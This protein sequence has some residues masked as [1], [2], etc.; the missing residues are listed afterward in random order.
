ML[1]LASVALSAWYY[2][3]FTGKLDYY[4]YGG[5]SPIPQ[6]YQSTP[7][8]ATLR[9]LLVAI[10]IMDAAPSVG[11]AGGMAWQDD[12]V[13]KVVFQDDPVVKVAFQDSPD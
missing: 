12:P 4:E 6:A 9:D 10:G 8:A 7:T 13:V 2:N 3:P 1:L 11:G 5:V